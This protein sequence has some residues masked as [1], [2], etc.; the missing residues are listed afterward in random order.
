MNYTAAKILFTAALIAT[1]AAPAFAQDEWLANSGR[2]VNGKMPSNVGARPTEPRPSDDHSSILAVTGSLT[3][4]FA[5]LVQAL[6]K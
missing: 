6:G 2:Y 1:I 4:D 5:S 3:S